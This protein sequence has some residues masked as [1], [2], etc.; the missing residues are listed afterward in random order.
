MTAL[1]NGLL[2]LLGVVLGSFA[3]VCIWRLPRRESIVW[4]PSHC[5]LCREKLKPWHMVPIFSWFLL[6]GKCAYCG[7]GISLRYP[8]VEAAT[9]AVFAA[10]GYAWGLSALSL[11]YCILSL[12][13]IISIGTDLSHR[14]I[15]DQ[16]SLGASAV[17]AFL[18]L[19]LGRWGNLL[20]GVLLFGILFL[21]AVLSKGGMGGGDIKLALAIGLGLGWRLGLLALALAVLTGGVVS[22][23]MLLMGQRKKALPFAPFLAA[24]AWLA[25]FLGERLLDL[26][27]SV[28]FMLSTW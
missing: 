25:M 6:R 15:P 22:V 9:A 19:I 11:Q 8:L 24:G 5:P 17:L 7:G 10:I 20:G 1:N 27:I 13:L 12:A 26:Y 14:E 2:F 28:V 18:A 16:V 21:I 23:V 4:P 3:N